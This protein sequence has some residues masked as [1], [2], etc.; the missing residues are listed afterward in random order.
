MTEPTTPAPPPAEGLFARAVGMFTSPGRTFEGVVRT[1]RPVGVL[2]LAAAITALAT[3]LPQFTE[4]GRQAALDMQQQQIEKFTGQPVTDETYARLEQQSRYGGYVTIV[5][6]FIGSPIAVLVFGGLYWVVFNTVLGGTAAFKQV[7]AVVS[8]STI[9]S[10]VGV[11][12]GAPIQYAKGTMSTTGP[13][14]LGALVPML[15]EKSFLAN[16][17]GFIDPFRVWGVVVTAIGL[18]VLYK[19]KSASIA[20]ALLIL[21]ALIA[22]GVAAWLSR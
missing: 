6:V 12:V 9:I 20:T 18:A 14:N 15:D 11:A 19:R 16:F 13:F 8:H 3:G 1:P 17:L 22:G 4:R 7:L 10:A 5:S 2:F 21:Y